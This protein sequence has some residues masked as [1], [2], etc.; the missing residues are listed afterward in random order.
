MKTGHTTII[1]LALLTLFLL[2]L[3]A[4][5]AAQQAQQDGHGH[6]GEAACP[7]Q[8]KSAEMQTT[9]HEQATGMHKG[10]DAKK[11]VHMAGSDQYDMWFCPWCKPGAGS[12]KRG[13]HHGE[14]MGCPMGCKR[15]G[16]HHGKGRGGMGM[17][18][19]MRHRGMHQRG[20]GKMGGDIPGQTVDQAKA[21]SLLADFVQSTG[22]PNIKVGDITDSGNV[23]TGSI[24]TQEGSL[25]DTVIIDKAT[26]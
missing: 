5:T 24:V 18:G 22:N 10:M 12:M 2:G 16:T 3:P 20:Y 23:F 7:H 4:W 6:H 25:V 8:A 9:S 17:H 21:K 1:F 19:G 14:K 26:G 15:G 11:G 13:M